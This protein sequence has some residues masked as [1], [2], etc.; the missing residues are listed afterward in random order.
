MSKKENKDAAQPTQGPNECQRDFV[1]EKHGEVL[2]DT[3]LYNG[4]EVVFY[5]N[6]CLIE[7]LDKHIGRI[8]TVK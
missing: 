8:K 6:K 1:C 7:F 5:C 3:R 2:N 4:Y